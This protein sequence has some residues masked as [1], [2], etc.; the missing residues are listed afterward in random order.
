MEDKSQSPYQ[1]TV[2]LTVNGERLDR[3]VAANTTLATL[4]RDGL[5]LKGT[6]IACDEAACG[7]CTVLVDGAP[8]FACHTLVGQLNLSSI[9]TIEGLAAGQALHPLQQ[10]FI[11]HDA[12]Q[13]GFCTPGM[14]M[15]LKSVCDAGDRFDR[16]S[17]ASSISGNICRCGA[18]EAIL[19]AALQVTSGR[20]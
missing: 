11:D 19:D 15:T 13:C 1:V 14:I 20:S 3:T 2:S 17:I 8:V 10:A 5:S 7:A 9:E 18:Y 16:A 12:T 6:K 4:L